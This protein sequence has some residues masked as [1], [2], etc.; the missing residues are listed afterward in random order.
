[1]NVDPQNIKDLPTLPATAWKILQMALRPNISLQQ[2]ADVIM[3]DL[4]LSGRILKTVNSPYYGLSRQVSNI[5]EGVVIL[6]MDMVKNIALSLTVMDSFRDHLDQDSYT[7]LLNRAL[8]TAV[9]A[10]SIADAT[11]LFPAEEAFLMGLFQDLGLFLLARQAPKE[12]AA[13]INEAKERGVDIATAL[14]ES[15][16]VDHRQLGL[17]LAEHWDLPEHIRMSI[18]YHSRPEEA[19]QANLEDRIFK[20]VLIAHL[21]YMAAEIY[22]DWGKTRR[23]ELFKSGYRDL[24]QRPESEAED[25]LWKLSE[26]IGAAAAGFQLQVPPA[27]SYASILGEANAELGKLNMRYEQ[28]YRELMAKA[29]E[30]NEKN[31]ELTELTRQ[32]D[33]KNRM[34]Q[35]LAA[36]DGLTGVY[37]H[38]YF[39][40]FMVQQIR[41]ARRHSRPLSLVILDID[42]FKKF[43]DTYGHQFGDL[44]LKELAAILLANVRKSDIV[45]RYGGEE[46]CVIL[47]DTDLKGAVR[48]AEKIRAAVEQAELPDGNGRSTRFTVSLGAAQ[49]SAKMQEPSDL[50]SIVDAALYVAKKGGR[51]RVSA[52]GDPN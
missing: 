48:V 41:Q 31:R 9:A 37:N 25:Q 11:G 4:A 51:N 20:C 46:F 12:F 38:R 26:R 18:R 21:A 35:D 39:Q 33:E 47:A 6:G 24:L 5:S 36:K 17:R 8:N 23:I 7:I 14:E 34:L 32:L 50:I 10:E 42:H 28:M 29:A 13:C 44:V 52:Y 16:R 40:E 45:A 49:L 3:T 27:R 15:M 30:L 22:T 1:M 19:R 2:M 43:N